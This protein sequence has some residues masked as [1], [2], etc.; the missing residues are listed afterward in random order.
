[1]EEEV[2]RILEKFSDFFEI[3]SPISYMLRWVGW[4]IIKCLAWLVDSLSNITDS[5]LGLKMFYENGEIT[6]LI[7]MLLP[8]SATLM[9]FSL[10]LY[11]V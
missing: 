2:A 4:A 7:K 11:R 5:V 1:M 10:L 3:T 8:L 6:S 9:A